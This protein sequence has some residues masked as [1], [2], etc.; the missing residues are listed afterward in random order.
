[1]L[2][3]IE[4]PRD[5]D[6]CGRLWVLDDAGGLAFGPAWC[7]GR[8]NEM[9]AARRGNDSRS[10][11]LPY[12]DTPLGQCRLRRIISMRGVRDRILQQFGRFGIVSLG[13]IGGPALMAVS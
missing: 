3:R 8:A 6:Y 5:R 4:L 9:A 7:T 12:G 11:L 13:A 2:I 10:C 1:M